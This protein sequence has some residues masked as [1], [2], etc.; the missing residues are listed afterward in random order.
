[1][2]GID[3]D[4]I[5]VRLGAAHYYWVH[6]TGPDGAPDASPV[7]GVVNHDILYMYT[8]R[9]SVKARNLARDPRLV[10]HLESGSDVTIVHGSAVD[11]GLPTEHP[12]I[13]EAFEAKYRRPEEAP[14]LP[15]S[16]PGFDV[17]YSIQPRRALVW[18]LPDSEA[19]TRR[20]AAARGT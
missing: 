14:F 1:M 8:F 13:V 18:A 6:T 3:W 11:M 7:W 9:S 15:S 12:D 17:L 4:E 20:W 19:S 2:T 5:A 16:D 10:V